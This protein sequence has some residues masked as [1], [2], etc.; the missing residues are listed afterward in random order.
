MAKRQGNVVE[1]HVHVVEKQHSPDSSSSSESD[2]TQSQVYRKVPKL[3]KMTTKLEQ[4]KLEC[5]R[6]Q[7]EEDAQQVYMINV[8]NVIVL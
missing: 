4:C 8:D 1:R 5:K 6:K 2:T 7:D 3:L